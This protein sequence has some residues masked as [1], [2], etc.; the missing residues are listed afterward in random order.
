MSELA[1]CP[2]CGGK[3]EIRHLEKWWWIE[4]VDCLARTSECFAECEAKKAWHRRHDPHNTD[5]IIGAAAD[6]ANAFEKWISGDFEVSDDDE[7]ATE[8]SN[9]VKSG[10]GEE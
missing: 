8:H 5:F 4:C 7:D 6:L 2:F 1:S 3:A 9:V 10:A